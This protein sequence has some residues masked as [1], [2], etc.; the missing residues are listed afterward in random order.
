MSGP[1]PGRRSMP[2]AAGSTS[3]AGTTPARWTW[4]S[5]ARRRRA[6]E[7]VPRAGQ[8]HHETRAR[9]AG[10]SSRSRRRCAALTTAA[11]SGRLFVTGASGSGKSSFAQAGL[12]P[13]LETSTG[14]SAGGAVGRLPALAFPD[15]RAGPGAARGR[16]APAQ[17]RRRSGQRW[18]AGRFIAIRPDPDAA[19]PGQ[20]DRAG[21]VRR[22]VHPVRSGPAGRAVR[23]PR[24]LPVRHGPDAPNRDGPRRLPAD[25][26][27]ARRPVR[28]GETAERRAARDGAA[29]ELS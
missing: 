1:P 24:G 9:Y 25:P 28:A 8:L 7:P 14:A 13:A 5:V 6:P 10:G 26:L 27:R 16:P 23:D 15:G 20:P 3:S 12:V 21:S 19:G 4:G 18:Y 17:G 29:D 11:T 2:R 22:A